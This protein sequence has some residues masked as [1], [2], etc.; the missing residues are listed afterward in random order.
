[1]AP[2]TSPQ[3]SPEA[4]SR[5]FKR[6]AIAEAKR[7]QTFERTWKSGNIQGIFDHATQSLK[8]DP[9][10][11]KGASLPRYGWIDIA[12]KQQKP[13]KAGLAKAK[14]PHAKKGGDAEDKFVATSIV[15]TINAFKEAHPSFKIDVEEGRIITVQ[16]TAPCSCHLVS[17]LSDLFR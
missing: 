12:E 10:L 17:D 14:K 1:M 7:M 13:T 15:P 11:T 8:T 16:P 6:T 3:E 2:F 9:D 5:D 4:L